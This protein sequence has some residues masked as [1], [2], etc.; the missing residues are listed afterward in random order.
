MESEFTDMESGIHSVESGIQDSLGLPYMGR[1]NAGIILTLFSTMLL[2][3]KNGRSVW[4]FLT[5]TRS[6]MYKVD[7]VTC[8]N[9]H[10][11][12]MCS[13]RTPR[14]ICR[15]TSRPT[16]R[17]RCRPICRPVCRPICRP[18]L[19]RYVGPYSG[20]H[21]ADTLTVEYRSKVGGLSVACPI[22]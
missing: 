20:R 18:M 6:R 11:R 22:I 12:I 5:A 16:Y 7:K 14:P 8:K 13:L 4:K 3:L 17:S 19:D 1:H 15:S 10:F 21:S 2:F 9:I